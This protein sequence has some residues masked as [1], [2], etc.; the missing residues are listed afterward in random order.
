MVEIVASLSKKRTTPIFVLGVIDIQQKML[1]GCF[2]CCILSR[3]G[4]YDVVGSGYKFIHCDLTY[5][6]RFLTIAL[7]VKAT[8]VTTFSPLL[9][10][11]SFI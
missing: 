4:S 2:E 6:A 7:I 1:S 11:G 8:F 9:N 10:V 5:K 3:Y